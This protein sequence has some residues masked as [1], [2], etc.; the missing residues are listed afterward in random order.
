MSIDEIFNDYDD[1]LIT[2]AYRTSTNR[3]KN[4]CLVHLGEKEPPGHLT[5]CK[6]SKIKSTIIDIISKNN[7]IIKNTMFNSDTVIFLIKVSDNKISY[8]IHISM[9]DYYPFKPPKVRINYMDFFDILPHSLYET[10]YFKQVFKK[11]CLCC[12]S[13]LCY[14]N[15]GPKFGFI[16]I[17]TEIYNIIQKIII[18]KEL[19]Y[20]DKIIDKYFGHFIPI[21]Q[22]IF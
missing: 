22:F 17:L 15:W 20:C 12:S 21:K 8:P 1:D 4:E 5:S 16:N 18:C 2:K 19:Y 9:T 10:K 6:K 14:N 13:I 11:E 7:P 3:F